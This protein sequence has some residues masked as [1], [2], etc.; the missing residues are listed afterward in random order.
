MIGGGEAVFGARMREIR[1]AKGLT[2]EELASAMD[3]QLTKQALSKY[4]TGKSQPR[5]TMLVALARALGVKAAELIGEPDYSIECLQY[6]TRAVLHPRSKERVEATLRYSLERRLRLEDRLGIGRRPMLPDRPR[7][8]HGLEEAEAAASSIRG[9]WALGLG[10]ISNFTEVLERQSIH[11]F[12]VPGDDDFDGLAAV[13]RDADG[14][15]RAVGIAENPDTAGDRQRFNL[16]HELGHVVVEPSADLDEEAV[17]H[18]FAGAFLLPATLVFDEVGSRRSEISLEE[19]MLLKQSW[20]VSMQCIL[21]RLRDLDVISQTHYEWWW[22]EIG[23]LGYGKVEPAVIL[24][25][26]STWERRNLARAQAEGL[27]TNEQTAAYLGVTPSA[28]SVDAIDR[29]ALMK[30]SLEDRRAVLRTHAEQLVDYYDQVASGEWL[31]AD[32]D[33]P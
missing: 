4:E 27:M 12:E 19:L 22:R 3:G 2:L 6:R 13:A 33:E 31:E 24:R 16:A 29:R 10:P 14:N 5:P 26:Q 7:P 18:R 25:E 32:L 1:L 17:A 30:L 20:G 11:V 8:V 9:E 21:H 28:R 23:A 15:L